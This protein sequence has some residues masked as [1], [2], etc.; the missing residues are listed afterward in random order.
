MHSYACFVCFISCESTV[1]LVFIF[2]YLYLAKYSFLLLYKV[3]HYPLAYWLLFMDHWLCCID[4]PP[5]HP[6]CWDVWEVGGAHLRLSGDAFDETIKRA[7]LSLLG[8]LCVRGGD[9]PGTML[10]GVGGQGCAGSVRLPPACCVTKGLIVRY[11]KVRIKVLVVKQGCHKTGM[12][13][14]L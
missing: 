3:P 10:G 1:T 9:E 5:P 12:S 4:P 6:R 11:L 7:L 13:C 8:I 2:I 14:G